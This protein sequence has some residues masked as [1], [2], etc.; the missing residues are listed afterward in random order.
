MIFITRR[1]GDLI[2]KIAWANKQKTLYEKFT[3]IDEHRQLIE[4]SLI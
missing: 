2:M 3:K 4:L 1:K